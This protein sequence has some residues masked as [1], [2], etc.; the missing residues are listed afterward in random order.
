[1]GNVDTVRRILC[2]HK[3]K[4]GRN[5]GPGS[6]VW[7]M[8]FNYILV[9]AYKTYMCKVLVDH[10]DSNR[11]KSWQQ[12]KMKRKRDISFRNFLD[13]LANR[14]QFGLFMIDKVYPGLRQK[15][16]HNVESP[17]KPA[18]SESIPQKEKD[19]KS[20]DKNTYR[21]ILNCMD[22]EKD[23][24]KI[25]LNKDMNHVLIPNEKRNS[26]NRTQRLRCVLCCWKC[27]KG[28]PQYNDHYRQGRTTTKMCLTC[29]VPICSNC[30]STFHNIVKLELPVCVSKVLKQPVGNEIITRHK[31]SEPI[32]KGVCIKIKNERKEINTSKNDK[33]KAN[34]VIK[35]VKISNYVIQR[36][37]TICNN[38]LGHLKF[39]RC[40]KE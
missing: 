30:N 31:S 11:L 32:K 13:S 17:S 9:N 12:L 36:T 27:E 8:I 14:D 20:E 21:F 2:Y 25:R 34:G 26:K 23:E 22:P 35:S 28:E 40:I 15:I 37:D 3:V 18:S 16:D 5:S 24:F 10:M 38:H 4:R 29:Q 33:R 39:L 1:M 6:L 7:Y 19:I